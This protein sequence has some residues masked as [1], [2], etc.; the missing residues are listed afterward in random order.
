MDQLNQYLTQKYSPYY[1]PGSGSGDIL[2]WGTTRDSQIIPG[3][4]S[5]NVGV[6]YD[7]LS[8]NPNLTKGMI[9]D[10]LN[11]SYAD[12]DGNS[13]F[14][15]FF[16]IFRLLSY[17]ADLPC[18]FIAYP[19]LPAYSDDQWEKTLEAYPLEDVRFYVWNLKEPKAKFLTGKELKNEIYSILDVNFQDQGTGKEKNKS[20]HD[21]FHYWSRCFL[22]AHIRKQD[23]DGILFDK[24]G[25]NCSL[26]E[27]KRSSNPPIPKWRPYIDDENN[28][29]NQLAFARSLKACFRLL[30]HEGNPV[31]EAGQVSFWDIR[32]INETEAER[33]RR[34][35]AE[36]H[37]GVHGDYLTCS[38]FF[39]PLPVSA[40]EE[41][42]PS[43]HSLIES[44][45][46]CSP[47]D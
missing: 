20:I 21:Y 42:L 35:Q 30:Q 14:A 13:P 24:S 31:T 9:T 46:D 37:R 1:I 44:F 19:T 47:G 26:I 5:L 29:R 17:R 41:N 38:R 18:I 28:Y 7:P 39:S 32:G 43:L 11:Q 25:T 33:L 40:K 3:F 8:P 2:M 10:T 23:C 4:L 22:S 27:I 6:D 34:L 16:R 36:G 45:I 15:A 12:F